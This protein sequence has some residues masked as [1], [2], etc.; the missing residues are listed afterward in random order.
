MIEV[1]SLALPFFGLIALGF[2][3]GRVKSIPESGLA[4]MNFFLIYVALPV[5]FYRILAQ[6]P[7]EK[8]NNPA[9]IIGTTLA[10]YVIYALAFAVT[11]FQSRGDI[12]R[13][14][15]GAV[16]GAY[17]NI[18]YMGPG[19]A[20]STIGAEAAAPVALIFCF[21]SLVFFSLVPL[22]NAISGAQSASIRAV[23]LETARKIALN[24][25]I[26]ATVLGVAA[27]LMKVQMPKG[28]DQLLLF[29]QNSAAP[30][31]LFTLGVTVALRFENFRAAFRVMRTI[32]PI[33]GLKLLVHPALA[34]LCL[35]VLGPFED[36]WVYTAVLMASLPPALNVFI[37]ARQYDTYIEEASNAVLMGTIISI[38]TLTTVL[39][40]LKM[41]L[42]PIN[43]LS[44]G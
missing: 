34:L 33:L 30:V 6:T 7:I 13:S 26:I 29:L 14:A 3:C 4:W 5:L 8:L 31:A 40:L 15:L 27:A 25:F 20:L 21:E 1:F 11:M 38:L 42:L 23:M 16:T 28:I 44:V 12:G 17:G 39:Y 18:G 22:L 36:A 43:L 19:L 24:P 9:F 35:S 32:A 2:F 10:T 41:Q 37:L